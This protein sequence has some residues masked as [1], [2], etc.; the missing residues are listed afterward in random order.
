VTDTGSST[1]TTST[2]RRGSDKRT[3]LVQAALETFH[4][5]GVE[6]STLADVASRADVPLGNVYYYFKT[7]DDLIAA[8]LES[9]AQAV[10]QALAQLDQGRTPKSRLKAFIRMLAGE[11]EQIAMHGCPQG[12]L[13]SELGKRQDR[14]GDS[15]AP[16]MTLPI[17]WAEQQF[18]EL[19]RRDARE[20]AVALIAA[21]QG[22]ALLT[23]T[24]RDPTLLITEARRLERWIDGLA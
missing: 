16:L 13:C 10:R 23:N 12:T 4:R 6:A 17:D 8:V 15:V 19:G 3:R 20:L 7:K 2:P 11:G 9:H 22:V 18:R 14:A 21:Y 1:T 5:Q 24:L